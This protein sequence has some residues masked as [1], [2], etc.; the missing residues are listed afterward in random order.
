MQYKPNRKVSRL[1]Q[2]QYNQSIPD[3][4]SGNLVHNFIEPI[5]YL[6]AI[7]LVYSTH[8]FL[9][10]ETTWDKA[11]ELQRGKKSPSYWQNF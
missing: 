1:S 5:K 6:E 11:I 8:L 10:V 2:Y 9:K 3:F 4:I 7:H